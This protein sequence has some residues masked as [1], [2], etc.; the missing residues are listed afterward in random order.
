MANYAGNSAFEIGDEAV[1]TIS[2]QYKNRKS[3]LQVTLRAIDFRDHGK[4]VIMYVRTKLRLLP[5]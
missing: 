2:D 5:R 4:R 3:R 1:D